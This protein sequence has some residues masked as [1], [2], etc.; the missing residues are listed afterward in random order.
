MRFILRKQGRT[1]RLFLS[2][3]LLFFI[4]TPLF[5]FVIVRQAQGAIRT[6]D[7]E[8]TEVSCPGNSNG[9][10]CAQNWSADTIPGSSD[11]ATFDGTSD[12]DAT[13]DAS[14]GG[15]VQGVDINSG[16]DGTITA[17]RSL[18]VGSSNFD[19]ASGTWNGAAQTLDINDGSFT[20]SGGSHTA[21]SGTW[22]VE[23]SFTYSGGTLTMTGATVTLDGTGSDSATGKGTGS[24]GGTPNGSKTG[25]N[26]TVTISGS[27]V[28]DSDSISLQG[29]LTVNGTLNHNGTTWNMDA[30]IND[31]NITNNGTITFD[32]TD[33][34]TQGD[35]N[36]NGTW[37]LSGKTITFDAS[38]SNHG[39]GITCSGTLGGNIVLTNSTGSSFTLGAGCTIYVTTFNN[40]GDV[41]V[42]GTMNV[43][44]STMTVNSTI[45]D[46]F[47]IN[48]GGI[49]NYTGGTTITMETDFTLN[50]GGS[51]ELTG[52]TITMD[53]DSSNEDQTI[54]CTGTLGGT[55]NLSNAAGASFTLGSGCTITVN[56]ID[57]TGDTT[58]D[59]TLIHT[60]TLFNIDNVGGFGDLT[61]NSGGTIIYSGT[62][63][64][65]S[66]NLTQNGTFDLSGKTITFDGTDDATLVCG[67]GVSLG[68][69][70]LNKT[71]SSSDLIMGS[72]CN[73]AGNFTRTDGNI[74]NPA[75]AYILSIEGN[76]SS[77]TTDT[78]GGANLTLAFTG[79]KTQTYTQNAGNISSPI[80]IDKDY[81]YVTLATA[82]TLDS[83]GNN[84]TISDGELRNSSFTLTAP[85]TLTVNDLMTQGTG[86]VV[87]GGI[88]VGSA[89]KYVNISTGDIQIGASGVTNS[90]D[91][92]L[93]NQNSCGGSDSIAITS[94]Q[95][96]TQR[97]W[98]GSGTF[99]LFDLT[100]TDQAGS[101]TITAYSSTP[102]NVG[103]NWTFSASCPGHLTPA[104]LV[105]NARLGNGVRL[106]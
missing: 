68:N 72:S 51:F 63:I 89:G 74:T 37:D 83:T 54:T 61:I 34:T 80:I 1:K 13:I 30:T 5:V 77:S 32:G 100:V 82:M 84:V 56:S 93:G 19:Q 52:K 97:D 7:G 9:W 102:S 33:I 12:K 62:N 64:T 38:S 39:P 65:L 88:S 55:W 87:V 79:P 66:R 6:W 103:S 41:T 91:I 25:G 8:G 2:L 98:A 101:A 49:V 105:Y 75:S 29:N 21:T 26:Q 36:Q 71:L 58:I 31:G 86:N 94:S 104:R 10:S 70:V 45:N 81:Y 92:T 3:F 73:I 16:Y 67:G 27:C 18:T 96:G 23:R 24:L 43:T 35:I 95:G 11:V 78:L 53:G 50:S 48:S 60:G 85:G 76:F 57:N 17:A 59:G 28:V 15:S 20:V 42:N 22:T 90:G 40:T 4:I 47:I 106:R 99:N 44:A 69:V 46:D 14:F